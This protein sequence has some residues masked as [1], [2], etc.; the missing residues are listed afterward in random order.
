[1]SDPFDTTDQ[2]I[3]ELIWATIAASEA[4]SDFSAYV[5][6]YGQRGRHLEEAIRR[7]GEC[8]GKPDPGSLVYARALLKLRDLAEAGNA[9]AAFHMGKACANGFGIKQ[10]LEQAEHWYQLGVKAGEARCIC[11][12]G[13]LYQTGF[14]LRPPQKEKAFALLARGAELGSAQAQASVGV[15]LMNGEGCPADP[16][17]GMENLREAFDK[18]CVGAANH[19]ADA[20]FAGSGV[21]ANAETA[22][23]W[24]DK[25]IERGDARTMAIAGHYLVTGSHGKTD[26]AK[27]LRLLEEATSNG[28]L[29]A[30]RWLGVLYER[31]N[32]V[33]QDVEL[34]RAWYQQ[35][36]AAGDA[37]CTSFLTAI[38]QR[39]FVSDA[40]NSSTLH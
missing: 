7:V 33:R 8:Y 29:P 14:G 31:G 15:M 5:S 35:G 17:R 23:A 40:A 10:N 28:Y 30:Y 20:Y 11:N 37:G 36:A 2:D 12:L 24:L 27:G 39:N 1:M 9:A 18:G 16:A 26:V 25:A 38:S 3:D 6:H 21:A 32:G 4:A 13:W 34:A 22:F 19:I